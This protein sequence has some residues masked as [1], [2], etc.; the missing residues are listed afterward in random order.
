MMFLLELYGYKTRTPSQAKYDAKFLH[1]PLCD[2]SCL[3]RDISQA[4]Y[5]S[6]YSRVGLTEAY[7]AKLCFVYKNFNF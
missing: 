1:D 3:F 7:C 6:L 5:M 4:D 2:A